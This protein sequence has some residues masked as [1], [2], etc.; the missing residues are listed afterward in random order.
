MTVKDLRG[1]KK[2]GAKSRGDEADLVVQISQLESDVEVLRDKLTHSTQETLDLKEKLADMDAQ[3]K[4]LTLEKNETEVK[5]IYIDIINFKKIK[6]IFYNI[7][8]IFDI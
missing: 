6:I 2:F 7:N 5:Y 8:E 4:Q 1:S 3:L